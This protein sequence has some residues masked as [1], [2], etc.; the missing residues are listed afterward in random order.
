MRKVKLFLINSF[1]MTATSL[2]LRIIGVSFNVYISNTIGLAGMGLI[3]IIMSVFSFSVIVASSGINLGATRLVAEELACKSHSGIRK[4]MSNC[5]IYSAVFGIFA[6][7]VLFLG[8]DFIGTTLLG[9]ERTVKSLPILAISLPFYS[10]QCVMYGYFTA[11]RKSFLTSIVQVFEMGSRIGLT[12]YFLE[13]NLHLGLE[14]ACIGLMTA[15]TLSEIIAFSLMFIVYLLDKRKYSKKDK[16][17]NNITKR[18]FKITLPVAFSSYV[19]SAL[20]TIKSIMIPLGL[21]KFG[22]TRD[23]ALAQFGVISGMVIPVILFPAAFLSTFSSLIVPEITEA[24][25]L[26]NKAR[27]NSMISRVFQISLIFTICVIGIFLNFSNEFGLVIYNNISIGVYIKIL[28]PLALIAY[29]H[30]R[31]YAKRLERTGK[32]NVLQYI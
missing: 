26:D 8:A 22:L 23:E 21:I 10:A 12:V 2:I 13:K 29:L 32:L 3:E 20:Q 27:I 4:S 1:A 5:L 14:Y 19:C 9:D 28:T 25:R 17:N 31:R 16:T 11:V 15:A 7:L 6:G 18:M 24:Y 30:S